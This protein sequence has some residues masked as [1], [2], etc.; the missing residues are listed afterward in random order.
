MCQPVYLSSWMLSVYFYLSICPP[1]TYLYFYL[2]TWLFVYISTCTLAFQ[3][4]YFSV[5]FSSC[6]SVYLSNCL[7]FYLSYL[8]V[9]VSIYSHHCLHKNLSVFSSTN[10]SIYFWIFS[11]FYRLL[12]NLSICLP[13]HLYK[14]LPASLPTCLNS[15]CLSV[16][17]ST[18][19]YFYLFF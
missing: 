14:L 5:Y 13:V 2:F 16:Y 11:F 17:L 9:N 3:S 4:I 7:S 18:Y 19:L 6:L 12:N 1:V 15:T 8:P 10:L